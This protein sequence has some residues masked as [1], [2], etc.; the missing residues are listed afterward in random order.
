VVHKNPSL[1]KAVNLVF[2]VNLVNDILLSI[3]LYVS[4]DYA[5]ILVNLVNNIY[6]K[7]GGG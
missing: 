6:C 7:E 5:R 4:D 2:L 3:C 1:E